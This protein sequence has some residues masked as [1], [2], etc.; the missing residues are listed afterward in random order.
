MF[1][2]LAFTGC[3]EEA[4]ARTYFHQL[5]NGLAYCHS[6]GVAHR[7]LKPENLLMDG[8]FQLK[9]A[10]FG[11]SN[12]FAVGTGA[13]PVDAAAASVGASPSAGSIAPVTGAAAAAAR[14]MYTECGTPGYMA[15]EVMGKKGYDP[16]GTD[17]WAC[18]V[19]LFI[20]L[21]GCKCFVDCA[22]SVC[23]FIV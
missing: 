21:A 18:G 17:I 7:D 10:D 2:F 6:Q 8:Q 9:L 3:F 19:I 12:V 16:V 5:I 14:L 23:F 13:V 11:L 20:M 15:P 4:I 22:L 1:E